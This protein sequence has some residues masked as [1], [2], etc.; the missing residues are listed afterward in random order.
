ME[1]ES[2]AACLLRSGNQYTRRIGHPTANGQ[3]AFL[4]VKQSAFSLYL[5]DEPYFHFDLEGRWQRAFLDGT[6]YRKALDGSIDRIDRLREPE[7]LVLKR[8]GLRYDEAADLDALVRQT[9]LSLQADLAAGQVPALAPP[10]GALGLSV[11]EVD[12]LLDRVA[13]WDGDAWF[14]QREAYLAIYGPMPLLPPDAHQSVI[15]QGTYHEPSV[16][17]DFPRTANEFEDHCRAVAGL[18]GRRLAQCRQVFLAGRSLPHLPFDDLR[19]FFHAT[20]R[21]FPLGAAGPRRPPTALPEGAAHLV[22]IDL[23]IED[24]A[25]PLP[26]T[27]QWEVLR[28]LHLGRVNAVV[29]PDATLTPLARM[30]AAGVKL[31]LIIPLQ[32]NQ[33]ASDPLRADDIEALDLGRDDLIYLMAADD[34]GTGPDASRVPED[35]VQWWKQRLTGLKQRSGCKVVV[36]SRDKEW[37]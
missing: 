16:E 8:R 35:H 22:G 3:L 11:E 24:L 9:A 36:Y 4:G 30:K 32:P 34:L 12:D 14:R 31:G 23:L 21:A 37:N 20:A 27:S 25:R 33:P 28:A 6:H 18:L 1:H 10:Q 17:R 26:D 19:A 15:L 7:G 5:G 13:R 2:E 29:A